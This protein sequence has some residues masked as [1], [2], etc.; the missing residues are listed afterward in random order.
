MADNS[1]HGDLCRDGSELPWQQASALQSARDTSDS[2]FVCSL[3]WWG[4]QGL[5]AISRIAWGQTIMVFALAL[6]TTGLGLDLSLEDHLPWLWPWSGQSLALVLALKMLALNP[7]LILCCCFLSQLMFQLLLCASHS[8][9]WLS[10][11]K[12]WPILLINTCCQMLLG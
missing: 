10:L 11:E 4:P 6:R 9:L 5:S 1:C 2:F 8:Q 7:F 12:L 3:Q